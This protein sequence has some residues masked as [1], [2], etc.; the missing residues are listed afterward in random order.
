MSVN[1]VLKDKNKVYLAVDSQSTKGGSKFIQTNINSIKMWKVDG[2]DSCYIAHTGDVR[3]ACIIRTIDDLINPND[4]IDYAYIVSKVKH[5]IVQE[6]IDAEFIDVS[7]GYIEKTTSSF[8]IVYKNKAYA[9]ETDLSVIE[10]EDYEAH[11]SGKYMATGSLA[12][13]VGEDPMTRIKKALKASCNNIYVD[14]PVYVVD[15]KSNEIITI[16]EEDL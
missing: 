6:L 1:I 15:T 5:K 9:I 11:G 8:L 14:F 16:T 13:T 7:D 10:I 4:E 2:V 12:S 3:D